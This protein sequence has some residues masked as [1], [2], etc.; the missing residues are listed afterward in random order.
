M[1]LTGAD[2][3]IRTLI[4]QG[5]DTV[6][7]YPGGQILNVYDSLYKYQN[8]IRHMLTAHEQGAAHAA[9]GYARAT[10]KVG[11]V[12]STSG[13]GATNLVT[14][15]ATAYLDSIP[16]VAI[17]GN[18]PT[19]QI[20][21]DSFQEIDITGVTLPIT[22]HNY[23]VGSVEN[24]AD[25]IREAFALAQSGRPG[26]VLIDVPKDVQTAVCD[27][28]PQA[29]VQPEERHAAKDVRIKEAAALI[30]V[31]K[32][33]FIYFGGGLITS[34]AQEEMLA[35]AE[36]IDA[37]IGCSLMGLSGIPTDH[38]RFLGM[39]GMHGHYAS[40]MAMHDADLI[41]SLGVRFNDRVTGNREK[42]AKLAQIIHIDVDGSELSKTVNSACGLRGDVKLTLQK[43]I[44]L[45]NAEQK[46]DWEKAVK[47]LKETENDYLDIR[48]G[49]TPRNAIMTLNKH[50]GENTAVATDVGQHQMWAAQ[51]V[52]FKKPRRFI[53]SGGLGTMGFGLGAAIGAAVGTGERSVLVTGD[54][55]FGMCL[56][57]LT[58]AVT[59]NVPVVILLMNNGVLGMVRQWQ[60]LFFNKHYSNTI[61]DRK[62]DFV[63]LARAFGADGEAVDTVAALD[64]AFEHAF[65]CDGPYVIDCRIDKDEFV[66]PMLPPGGSMDDIIMKVGE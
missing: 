15:I 36:K 55:S 21:T 52:N 44:P 48:P 56:N 10:G 40:S 13:P 14:G 3:L 63:A 27:Y 42:F 60:T 22:K 5:C 35:L 58:T 8:E 34:E 43:L 26:P 61:L 57:E 6:F 29:P 4:E 24:L 2:I 17:C 19:T 50:L 39:Q 41:I 7:G 59:Y 20:G 49:L 12:M 62:T 30:N 51:N 1:Q 28:E 18:V 47:A 46:P 9:D 66:L 54:G 38:P 31:S 37:P 16:L 64:K 45:V 33:P 32:R 23:F 11:V 25:T 53:S 65:S